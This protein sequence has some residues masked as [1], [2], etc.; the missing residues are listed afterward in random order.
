MLHCFGHMKINVSYLV[1]CFFTERV[2]PSMYII[3]CLYLP[4]LPSVFLLN[5]NCAR[6]YILSIYNLGKANNTCGI[7]GGMEIERFL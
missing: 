4:L 5:Y 7:R 1:H 3:L 2:K 6:W